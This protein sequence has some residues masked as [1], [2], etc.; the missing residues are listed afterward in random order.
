MPHDGSGRG[1]RTFPHSSYH[2][3]SVDG[4]NMKTPPPREGT[5]EINGKG[6]TVA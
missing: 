4:D 2:V 6:R 3:S 1:P 5:P